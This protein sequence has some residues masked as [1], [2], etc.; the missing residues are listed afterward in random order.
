MKLAKLNVYCVWYWEIHQ[1]TKVSSHH[2]AKFI[3]S[4]LRL[5][6]SCQLSQNLSSIASSVVL[7]L[8][9]TWAS[10]RGSWGG[11]RAVPRLGLD[12]VIHVE[13][14]A[15][16]HTCIDTCRHVYWHVAT[17]TCSGSSNNSTTSGNSSGCGRSSYCYVMCLHRSHVSTRVYSEARVPAVRSRVPMPWRQ[18]AHTAAPRPDHPARPIRNTCNKYF[19]RFYADFF[20]ILLNVAKLWTEAKPETDYLQGATNIEV[21]YWLRDKWT[22]TRGFVSGLYR[23]WAGLVKCSRDREVKWCELH[24]SFENWVSEA[25][26]KVH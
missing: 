20:P 13:T 6:I 5:L 3:S 26:G 11:D 14:P 12:H 15:A 17:V 9:V 7:R 2:T 24:L 19:F 8:A 18:T 22:E 25:R 23:C 1:H 4:L 10:R 16:A 21:H